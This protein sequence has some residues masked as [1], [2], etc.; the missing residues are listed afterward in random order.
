VRTQTTPDAFTLYDATFTKDIGEFVGAVLD[1]T[2]LTCSAEDTYE[3][4]KIVVAL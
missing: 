4:A 1:G 2:P 3:A